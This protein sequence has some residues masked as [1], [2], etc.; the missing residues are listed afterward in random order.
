MSVQFY[1]RIPPCAPAD[2][3]ASFV[4]ECED[5]GFAGVGI[6]DSPM[7]LRE[8]FVTM[9]ASALATSRIRLATAVTNPATRHVSVLASAAKAVEELAPGR[10]EIWIGR[11]MTATGTIGQPPAPLED[12]RESIAALQKLLAGESIDFNGVTS[13]LR[14]GGG[15]HIPV[16]MAATGPK[17]LTLAG[18]VADGVLVEVGI[19]PQVIAEVRR[20]IAEGARQTGRDPTE[21]KLIASATTI[22]KD[23]LE[24]ARERARLLAVHWLVE[25]QFFP[26]LRTAG[27][28][29]DEV[30]L[31][32]E[33]WELYP[34]VGHAIDQERARQLCSFLPQEM[35]VQICDTLGF[36]G[37]PEH[38]AERVR[39]TA[40]SGLDG[41]FLKGEPT[42][43]L[44]HQ[45]MT[46]FRDIVFPTLAAP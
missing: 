45:E 3:I 30:E 8:L 32:G 23:D 22:I 36:I 16:Y 33:L 18:A 46:A 2:Q 17:A 20:Y 4:R 27:V 13:R 42:Y 21:V 11:G 1:L 31:P 15:G 14:H 38:C 28:E 19:H 39:E 7:L 41:L 12:V 25:R 5:A 9:T 34:D 44:P 40:A 26:W 29:T 43:E 10:V 6:L 24:V 35:L 37:T